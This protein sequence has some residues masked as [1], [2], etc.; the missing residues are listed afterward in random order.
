MLRSNLLAWQYQLYGEG[1]TTRTNLAIHLVTVPMFHMGLL[2]LL[3]GLVTLSGFTM[4]SGW[5]VAATCVVLQGM[6]HKG[7]PVRP[8]PFD[9]PLDV[10][11]RLL[12]E[13]LVTFPRFVLS[14]GFVRAWASAGRAR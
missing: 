6:G 9:G 14:G 1:H 5:V 3:L 7:E 12:V 4:L 2:T 11:S 8:V 13:Q 10:A